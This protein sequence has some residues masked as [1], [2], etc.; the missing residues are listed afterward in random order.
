MIVGASSG[1]GHAAAFLFAEEGAQVA[2]V[3]R[4]KEK[5]EKLVETI[6]AN[7]GKAFAIQADVSVAADH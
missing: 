3:A 7:G 4:R 1:I 2:V 5:L 6:T